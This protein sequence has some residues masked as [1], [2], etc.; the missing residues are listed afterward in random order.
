MGK[1]Q[2]RSNKEVR[3]PKAAKRKKGLASQPRLNAFSDS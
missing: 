3:E 1:G 2:R